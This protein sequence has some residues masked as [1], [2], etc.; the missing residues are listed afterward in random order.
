[1]YVFYGVKKLYYGVRREGELGMSF[2][3]KSLVSLI[4]DNLLGEIVAWRICKGFFLREPYFGFSSFVDRELGRNFGP[5]QR[6]GN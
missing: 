1:V 6:S 4:S 3:L 2:A 5:G